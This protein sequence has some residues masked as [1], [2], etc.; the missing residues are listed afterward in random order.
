[1]IPSCRQFVASLADVPGLL[2]SVS[3]AQPAVKTLLGQDPLPP[4]N[5]RGPS[6]L[7]AEGKT[8]QGAL[9]RAATMRAAETTLG[10][11]A[12]HR[13]AHDDRHVQTSP[14]RRDRPGRS[15][16]VHEI[17]EVAHKGKHRFSHEL[18]DGALAL[19]QRGVSGSVRG[20]QEAMGTVRLNAPDFVQIHIRPPL[21]ADGGVQC[22]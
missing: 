8:Q 22:D 19:M 6:P 2:Q 7:T 21:C 18:V 10:I 13:S 11:L 1:M 5:P 4:G 3:A 20:A 12:A 17:V 15:A 9:L 14:R 16:L